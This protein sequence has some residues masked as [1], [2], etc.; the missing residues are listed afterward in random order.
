MRCHCAR[1]V[2]QTQQQICLKSVFFL[3]FLLAGVS[4]ALVMP[5]VS[6]SG[7]P[8]LVVS[9]DGNTCGFPPMGCFDIVFRDLI[10]SFHTNCRFARES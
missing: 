1:A 4:I 9:C 6:V 3:V 7:G 10:C 8:P 2:L 5:F